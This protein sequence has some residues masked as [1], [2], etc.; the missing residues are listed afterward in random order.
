MHSSRLTRVLI[1]AAVGVL[2]V[3]GLIVHGPVGGFMLA[4][5]V[6]GLVVLS[7]ATWSTLPA[8]GRVARGLVIGVLGA[9]AVVKFAGK[10]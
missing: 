5:V 6:A 2:V 1:A 9:V 4:I 3:A 10:A 8:R 7:S